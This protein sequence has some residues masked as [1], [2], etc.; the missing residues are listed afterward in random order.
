MEN[1]VMMMV[2]VGKDGSLFMIL[3]ITLLFR[4]GF[5]F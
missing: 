1:K 5:E 3:C 4:K 2:D